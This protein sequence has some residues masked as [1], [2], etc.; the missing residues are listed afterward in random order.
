LLY[1]TPL[2]QNRVVQVNC[3]HSLHAHFL[4]PSGPIWNP[5]GQANSQVIGG[6]V[7]FKQAHFLHPVVGSTTYPLGHCK[8]QL[9]ADRSGQG[10]HSQVSHPSFPLL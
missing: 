9:E 7:E 4:H 10:L 2:G 6:Q 5:L 8:L 1:L 3:G